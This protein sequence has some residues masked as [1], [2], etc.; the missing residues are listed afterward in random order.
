MRDA[1]EHTRDKL[2]DRNGWKRSLSIARRRLIDKGEV[3]SELCCY[4]SHLHKQSHQLHQKRL[5]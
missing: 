2:N 1:F 5:T 4:L 3:E